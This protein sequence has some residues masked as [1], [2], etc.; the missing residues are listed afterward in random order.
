MTTTP[1]TQTTARLFRRAVG[2]LVAF[3]VCLGPLSGVPASAG[4]PPAAHDRIVS[5]D[6]AD[7]TPHVLNGRVNAIVQ[8]GGTVIVGGAF[9]EVQVPGG[10]IVERRNLFAFDAATGELSTTFRP[11]ISGKVFALATDG[12]HVFVGGEFSRLSGGD[13]FR[14]G[15]LDLNGKRVAGFAAPVTGAVVYDLAVA[16]GNLYVGG[17]FSAVHGVA[18]SAFAV[19]DAATGALR[20]DIDVPFTG[21]HNGGSTHV[22]KLDVTPDGTKLVAVG[23]FTAV[24]GQSR[25]QIA[26]LDLTPTT[27]TVSGWATTRYSTQCSSRFE[28]YIRDVDIAPDGTYFVVVTTGA[29][30]GGVTAGVL[31]DTAARWEIGPTA[32]NQQPT[33]VDY[34]GGDTTFSVSVTGT[35]V[36]VGGHFRWWNNPYA[37]DRVGPGTIKRNGIAALDPVNG[38]PLSW[39]PGRKLGV[40]VFAFLATPDGLW[41]GSDTDVIGGEIHARLA[42]FPLAGGTTVPIHQPATLPGRLFTLSQTSPGTALSVRSFDGTT[43]GSRT[44]LATSVDWSRARGAFLTGGRIYA[45]WDDGRIYSRRFD[46]TSVGSKVTQAYLRG[47]T[48]TH[49]PVASVTGMFYDHGRGRLYY[50]VN[51]DGRLFY[52]YFTPESEVIGAVTFVA[53]GPNDGFDWASV[54][55][56]TLAG[57]ALYVARSWGALQRIAWNGAPIAGTV[58]VVDADPAQAW[59]SRGLVVTDP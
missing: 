16:N 6:P 10:A 11:G 12:T 52:R 17:R 20:A 5:D 18:R 41:V 22:A 59:A 47:L 43:A 51:G 15:K 2:L 44:E 27:A 34:A 40:G 19:V 35:A 49:F 56:M 30:F 25:R 55:G 42:F 9:K 13:V 1:P 46:G 3:L 58:T 36:Y 57:D 31:C 21:I 45:G 23:N 32:A 24:G 50:T 54:R 53:T 29:F 14:L 4:P 37:G 28:T 48:T 7:W 38:L 8:V 26:M 39:N 33:W